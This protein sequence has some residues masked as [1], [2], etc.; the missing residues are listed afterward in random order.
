MVMLDMKASYAFACGPFNIR[1]ARSMQ[2][3]MNPSSKAAVTQPRTAGEGSNK[4]HIVVYYSTWAV[5][6]MHSATRR[7][8]ETA[9]MR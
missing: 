5:L 3:A 6:S 8:S 7:S 2:S 9:A 1:A 4:I